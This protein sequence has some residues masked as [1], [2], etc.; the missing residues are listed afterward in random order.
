[1]WGG[2]GSV[3]APWGLWTISVPS[4]MFVSDR[5]GARGQAHLLW[6]K[7]CEE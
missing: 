1:M 4:E 5:Q 6:K 3:M 2:H 7:V